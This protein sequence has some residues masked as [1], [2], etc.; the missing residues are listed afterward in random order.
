MKKILVC[1]VL[2][3]ASATMV[4]AQAQG[5]N[6][7]AS[8]GQ[9]ARLVKPE[10]VQISGKLAWTNGRI[11]VLADNTTYYVSGIGKLV[12][13]VDGIKEGAAVSLQGYERKIKAVPDYKYFHATKVTVNG[14]DYEFDNERVA[15]GSF[16]GKHGGPYGGGFG[17]KNFG[18]MHKQFGNG[19]H[20]QFGNTPGRNFR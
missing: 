16:A 7:A 17:G 9:A 8:Q 13:F 10:P 12:G 15:L 3:A 1:F 11:A 6:G 4:F 14:K 5:N 19:V 18:A 2:A 20:K